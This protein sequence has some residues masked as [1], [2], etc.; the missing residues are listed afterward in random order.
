MTSGLAAAEQAVVDQPNDAARWY[1]LGLARLDAGQLAES[2]ACWRKVLALNPRHARAS[3]NLGLVLQHL[4]RGTEALGCYR[5]AVAADPGLAQA[6]FNLG[7]L[8]IDRAEPLEALA[9]L[10]RAV[11]LDPGRP[12]AHAALGTALGEA[13]F[14]AEA[15]ASLRAALERD[16]ALAGVHS[17]LLHRLNTIAG[18]SPTRLF[19]EHLAWARRNAGPRERT[20]GNSRDPDR[21]IRVGYVAADFA[22][23]SIAG[24]LQAVLARHDPAAFEVFCYSD[25]RVADPVSWRLRALGVRWHA[26]DAVTNEQFAT[27]LRGDGI[28][29]L[30]DLA[31]H[32]AGGRRMALFARGAAPVQAAWLGYPSTTGLEAIDYRV[33]DADLCPNGAQSA[34]TEHLV[35]LPGSERC[36]APGFEVARERAQRGGEVR[37]GSRHPLAALTPEVVALWTKI[38]ERVPGSRLVLAVPAGARFAAAG[39]ARERIEERADAAFDIALDAFPA[40]SAAAAIEALRAGLPV[41]ALRG[42]GAAS[43]QA[44]SILDRLGLADLVADD[45]V[46]YV[47]VAVT[48]ARDAARLSR[49]RQELPGSVDRSELADAARFTRGLESAYRAMWRAWCEDRPARAFDVPAQEPSRPVAGRP[50]IHGGRAPRV[51]LDGV[52]FQD[53][54]TGISRVWQSV[55]LEWVKSGFADRVVLLDRQRTAPQIPGVSRRIVPRHDYDRLD[56]DCAMLERVCREEN[57]TV[58]VSTYYS[59]P[60]NT[61]SVMLAYDMIPE[62]FSSDLGIPMWREKDACIRQAQRIVAISASTAS[63]LCDFYPAVGRDQVTVAHCGVSPW[64]RPAQSAEI[65]GFMR[66]H[67]IARPYFLIVGSRTVYKNCQTFLRA[68]G[69]WR[70]RPRFAVV[71]TG[72]EKDLEPELAALEDGNERH[73]LGLGD[74]ELRLAYAGAVALAYP[75]LYEGFGMPVV[76]AMASGCP[77]ITTG[78]ASLPEVAGDA[79]LVVKPMDE[80]ALQEAMHRV[81]EPALRASLVEK[82]L[83][84]ARLFSWA[85]MAKIIEGALID[86]GR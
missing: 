39:I 64:F 75:S 80:T 35:R 74:D 56:D 21:R 82:G 20:W 32:S 50:V 18:F 10:K 67:R 37:F 76:E 38:L 40:S 79:A 17:E 8:L 2:E 51:V 13:G 45:E 27:G 11:Q 30:V 28:D 85:R 48:L 43:R 41:V 63:D 16:P 25:A 12:E 47:E 3:V 5:A 24:C 61:P 6:W 46:R 58:F 72:G 15:V 52:F 34:Y 86:A 31:G 49:M 44:A 26:V 66:R 14:P 19:E 22:D 77:V 81:Q 57:A 33:T 68:F 36:F 55:L 73:L 65:D 60:L 53:F 42:S 69:A 78:L 84:Q 9:P 7:A 83:A 71:C 54:N 1:E 29:I 23:P 62:V 70:E 4:A 59:R